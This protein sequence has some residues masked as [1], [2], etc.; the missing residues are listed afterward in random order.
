MSS[1]LSAFFFC[2]MRLLP[3]LRYQHKRTHKKTCNTRHI[4]LK[5][6]GVFCPLNVSFESWHVRSKKIK[7]GREGAQLFVEIWVQH[8]VSQL[9]VTRIVVFTEVRG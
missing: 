7:N 2:G 6:S 9:S 5:S 3:V 4:S 8:G 1:K